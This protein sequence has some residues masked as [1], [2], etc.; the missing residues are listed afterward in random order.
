MIDRLPFCLVTRQGREP[1]VSRLRPVRVWYEAPGSSATVASEIPNLADVVRLHV[2]PLFGAFVQRED[3]R[4]AFSERQF[5][6]V[7]LH[8]R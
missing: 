3:T 2:L 8:R 7:T 4:M 1:V 6:S 5:D